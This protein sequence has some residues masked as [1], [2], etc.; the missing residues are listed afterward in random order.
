MRLQPGASVW[1]GKLLV[2]LVETFVSPSSSLY[3]SFH[4]RF[5]QASRLWL[6]ARI[7]RQVRPRNLVVPLGAKVHDAHSP[8]SLPGGRSRGIWWEQNRS[9]VVDG[10]VPLLITSKNPA[11][12]PPRNLQKCARCPLSKVHVDVAV[13]NCS[14]PC[15]MQPRSF[16][17]DGVDARSCCL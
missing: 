14:F 13:R 8:V 4:R 17:G 3:R 2:F 11:W 7:A 1:T 16:P 9:A 6:P 15:E 5:H 10:P 12:P